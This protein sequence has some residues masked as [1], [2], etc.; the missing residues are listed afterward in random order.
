MVRGVSQVLVV[1]DDPAI[2]ETL[3]DV[4]QDEGIAATA[5]EDG[6]QALGWLHRHPSEAC[7]VLLDIMMPVMDGPAFLA[8]KADDPSIADLPVVLV[9]ASGADVCERVAGEHQVERCLSKPV[10][11]TDLLSAVAACC[12]TG[13]HRGVGTRRD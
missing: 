3:V 4:L 13:D 10:S 9:S 8:A 2:R 1:D 12:S 5:V 7:L 6:R 11:L